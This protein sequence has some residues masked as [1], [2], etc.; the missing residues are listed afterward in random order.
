MTEH[1][2]QMQAK[3]H[4]QACVGKCRARWRKGHAQVSGRYANAGARHAHIK[5]VVSANTWVMAEGMFLSLSL[6]HVL[7]AAASLNPIICTRHRS[8]R[9]ASANK[10]KTRTRTRKHA[11]KAI[12]TT[13]SAPPQSRVLCS[14]AHFWGHLRLRNTT[15]HNGEE[16]P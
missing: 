3:S 14:D 4:A 5:V 13:T 6:L 8:K 16:Q 1:V 9:Q 11:Q 10:G 15:L 7:V 2:N 12:T